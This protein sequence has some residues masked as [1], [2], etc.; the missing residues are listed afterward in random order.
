M[1]HPDLKTFSRQHDYLICIDSDGTAIDAMNVK[2]NQCH[3]PCFIAE[4][5]LEDH[6]AEIQKIWN[7]INLYSSTRGVNRYIALVSML[8]GLEGK[9]LKADG[10]DVLKNWVDNASDLS[11][12]CLRE[13]IS[14]NGGP[15]LKKAL[16]WSLAVNER[17]ARLTPADKKPFAGVEECLGYAHGKVDIAVISSSNMDAIAEEWENYD[18]LKYLG[19]MTSQE[20]GTKGKCIAKMMQKGYD[21]GNVLMIGDA[22]P[23]V[24][25][26]EVTGVFFYP[27]LMGHERESW[28]ELK[29]VYL[30]EFLSG[31]YKKYQKNFIEKFYKN[32]LD[33]EIK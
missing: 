5:G 24:D 19:V 27:V 17:I 28:V 1:N 22:L 6:S 9:F 21:A 18:L 8:Q 33:T 11:N 29:E 26:A 14:R 32:F 2:H 31:N 7:E 3:G 12:K 25:A 16:N 4:W 10:L 30:D 20:I 13:E 23:D 15:I